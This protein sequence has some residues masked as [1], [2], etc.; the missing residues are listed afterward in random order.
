VLI[1]ILACTLVSAATISADTK[2]IIDAE[3][4]HPY[5][6]SS[7][8]LL[9]VRADPGTTSMSV[10]FAKLDITAGDR[11]IVYDDQG[12]Q[13]GDL[14]GD[15][16]LGGFATSWYATDD[17]KF[18]ILPWYHNNRD[19]YG[20]K[21]DYILERSSIPTQALTATVSAN[22]STV[23]SGQN[24]QVKIHV[25]S[26][27][28]P[29]DTANIKISA[30]N[31]GIL[32]SLAG[33]TD[34]NGDLPLTF[35]APSATTSTQCTITADATKT[36][37]TDASG[38]GIITVQAPVPTKPDIPKDLTQYKSDGISG[39][40]FG[41]T[42]NENSVVMK[43]GVSDPGS[44]KVQLEV[45]VEPIGKDFTGNPTSTSAAVASGSIASVICKGLSEGKYH[46]QARAKNTN[47]DMSSWLSAGS[48]AETEAD[49][50]VQAVPISALIVSVSVSPPS[51]NSGQNS[52]VKIHV[53]SGGAPVSGASIKISASNGGVLNPT[54]GITDTYGDLP[55]TFTAPTVTTPTQCTI[56]AD[57]TKTGYNSISGTGVITV[58]PLIPPP[59]ILIVSVSE[60]PDPVESGKSSQ[61]MVHVT[62]GGLPVN[63]AGITMSATGGNLNKMG[64]TT[65][66][67]GN[68]MLMFKAPIVTTQ[69]SYTITA[70][71]VMNGYAGATGADIITVQP[72]PS[73]IS[74]DPPSALTQYK[75][76]GMNSLP[77]GGNTNENSVVVKGAVSDSS[78]S[79]VQLEVEVEPIGQGFIGRPTSTSFFVTSGRTASAV[80][81]DLPVG[82]YHWQA[83]ARNMNGVVG[84][85]LSA[86]GNVETDADFAVTYSTVTLRISPDS[87]K[88]GTVFT[89]SGSGYTPNG[90]IEWHIR[91]PNRIEYR[92]G[93][94]RASGRGVVKNKFKSTT[95]SMIGTYT[96]WAVDKTTGKKSNEVQAFVLR[97]K[98]PF[99]R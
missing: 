81:R 27:G 39:L 56:T 85:W 91:K 80:C 73:P 19:A 69:T 5:S 10:H 92:V 62:S 38:T 57:V 75:A 22:P 45:E 58:Q 25:E 11:L 9:D 67:N 84:P 66:A 1:S 2:K 89:I 93:T 15:S 98:Q 88:Q 12:N 33:T 55:L 16:A 37:Y 63:G 3:T 42:T 30:S 46:W 8:T 23:N 13:I 59:S 18:E 40:V 72:P 60:Y 24:S 17:V 28:K 47:G 26:G 51:V 97:K 6:N 20:I 29:V 83:R 53:E 90:A 94:L 32:S 96:F 4:D 50:V 41:G 70:D 61:V 21:V 31:G 65:D 43:G 48:N 82:A 86:G 34:K 14:S 71:A 87:G 44:S 64:G 52:Q 74:P 36:G 99:H 77:F 79:I 49:F 76:N 78:G 7:N 95:A 68:L 35:T 54:T